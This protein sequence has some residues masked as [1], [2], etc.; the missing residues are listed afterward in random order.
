MLRLLLLPLLCAIFLSAC[1]DEGTPTG[2]AVDLDPNTQE[3]LAQF[4]ETGTTYTYRQSSGSEQATVTV[5]ARTQVSDRRATCERGGETSRCAFENALLRFDAPDQP[6]MYT[7][8][9]LFAEDRISLVA[10][11]QVDR[12]VPE[13][14]RYRENSA[15]FSDLDPEHFSTLPIT[16]FLN[17]DN[18]I[19][20]AFRVVNIDSIG[21]QALPPFAYTLVKERGVVEWTDRAGTIWVAE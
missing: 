20:T 16:G 9:W 18:S 8:I 10:A 7:G 17:P 12:L 3:W 2:P 6:P 11:D 21:L 4:P 13:I 1:D 14:A 15:L 19:T 5:A